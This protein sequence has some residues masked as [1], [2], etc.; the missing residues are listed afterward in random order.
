MAWLPKA[1]G[2]G[3]AGGHG[4][5]DVSE[6]DGRIAGLVMM[7]PAARNLAD[8]M[9]E[10]LEY[11]ANLDG[12]VGETESEQIREVKAAVDKI[13]SGALR[14]GEMVLGAPKAYWDDL[15][16]DPVK[17]PKG[18]PCPSSSFRESGIIRLPWWIWGSGQRPCPA[19]QM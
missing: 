7:A 19:W 13:K 1:V 10:Q 15:E 5:G 8:L 3:G 2:V 4:D 18:S 11:L 14:E 17:S 6:G 9:A 16:N 12:H